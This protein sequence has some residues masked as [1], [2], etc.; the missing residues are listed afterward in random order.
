[1][2]VHFVLLTSGT[3]SDV[4]VDKGGKSWPPEVAL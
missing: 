4:V 2:G 1:M 3:T